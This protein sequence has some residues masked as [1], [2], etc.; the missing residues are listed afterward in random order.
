MLMSSTFHSCKNKLVSSLVWTNQRALNPASAVCS[1]SAHQTGRAMHKHETRACSV[2]FAW[3]SYSQRRTMHSFSGQNTAPCLLPL[4][5]MSPGATVWLYYVF[6][7]FNTFGT[8]IEV[9]G[10]VSVCSYR[11]NGLF[12]GLAFKKIIQHRSYC[13]RVLN[14]AIKQR[15]KNS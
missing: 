2:T 14:I 8:V 13:L 4:R 10:T 7:F 5:K 11:D 12:R 15:F 9:S 3:H 1:L 6:F